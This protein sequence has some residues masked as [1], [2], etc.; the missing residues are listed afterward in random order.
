M[1]LTYF[2]SATPLTLN[3]FTMSYKALLNKNN[4]VWQKTEGLS[5]CECGQK[6]SG[7]VFQCFICSVRSDACYTLCIYLTIILRGKKW[8]LNQGAAESISS[9]FEWNNKKRTRTISCPGCHI[10]YRLTTVWLN[11]YSSRCGIKS[12][13]AC[14]S[15][16]SSA[17]L[18]SIAILSK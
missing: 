13:R 14:F 2:L 15:E 10:L 5:W 4:A 16:A 11:H 8:N 7:L 18:A 3:P 1:L 17:R 9:V 12:Q 6:Y